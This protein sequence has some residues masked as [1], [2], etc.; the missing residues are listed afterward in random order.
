M[1]RRDFLTLIGLSGGAASLLTSLE[2]LGLMNVPQARSLEGPFLSQTRNRKKV[3]IL[4]SGISGM[5][6]A[7]ELRKAGYDCTIVEANERPGGRCFTL[8]NGTEV[9]EV[10]GTRAVCDF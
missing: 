5:V 9:T 3:L 4:G 10:D 7:L 2:V 1:K 8:R 6:A